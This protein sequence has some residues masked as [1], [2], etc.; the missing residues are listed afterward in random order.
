ME[1]RTSIQ[2]LK[3]AKSK[4]EAKQEALGQLSNNS[5][6]I[7]LSICNYALKKIESRLPQENVPKIENA[8]VSISADD[9]LS[10]DDIPKISTFNLSSIVK[11]EYLASGE[12]LE[13][14][15]EFVF[16]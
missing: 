16:L 4:I 11:D 2:L 10:T 15:Q 9:S 7:K 6:K 8:I 13:F 1:A 14:E 3:L 12:I 5:N